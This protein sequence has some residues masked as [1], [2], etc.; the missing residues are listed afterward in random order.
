MPD[1]PGPFTP[2]AVNGALL[3]VPLL[4]LLMALALALFAQ[5][6]SQ[7]S[8]GRIWSVGPTLASTGLLSFLGAYIGLGREPAMVTLAHGVTLARVGWLDIGFDVAFDRLTGAFALVGG[9]LFAALLSWLGRYGASGSRPLASLAL[10]NLASGAFFFALMADAAPAFVFG[11]VASSL[12]LAW[13]A[14]RASARPRASSDFAHRAFGE[15]LLVL[16]LVAL[17]ASFASLDPDA[18]GPLRLVPVSR[19]DAPSQA[20]PGGRPNSGYLTMSALPGASLRTEGSPALSALTAPFFRNVSPAGSYRGRVIPGPGSLDLPFGPTRIA[21][22]AETRLVLA[23]PTVAFRAM[24]EQAT[25]LAPDE[26][27]PE[28]G[29]GLARAGVALVAAGALVRGAFVGAGR[30]RA[31]GGGLAWLSAAPLAMLAAYLLLRLSFAWRPPSA[32]L[33]GLGLVAALATSIGAPGARR[34]A[35]AAEALI[36]LCLA[37][38]VASAGVGAPGAVLAFGVAPALVA[39]VRF[40]HA[41]PRASDPEP[42]TRPLPWAW[43]VPFALIGIVGVSS[44]AGRLP[45]GS[46]GGIALLVALAPPA[47]A[48]ALLYARAL[49]R[50]APAKGTS[51]A[52]IDVMPEALGFAPSSPDFAPSAAFS[53][54][55]FAPD[56]DDLASATGG[57][58][59]AAARVSHASGGFS[60]A[61]G[62]F[63]AISGGFAPAVPRAEGLVLATIV[64]ALSLLGAEAWFGLARANAPALQWTTPGAA[65]GSTRSLAALGVTAAL[66]LIAWFA[67]RWALGKGAAFGEAT[68]AAAGA[69][70]RG[71]RKVW[72]ALGAPGRA[73]WVASS[74]IDRQLWGERSGASAPQ[75]PSE[76]R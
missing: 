22:N 25:L 13:L 70:G 49:G 20:K 29:P 59:P 33:V 4:P 60:R 62:G 30:G 28:H 76:E 68:P 9:S 12:A 16:G 63:G 10:G 21:E 71:V 19:P 56:P 42:G 34:P 54:G 7:A 43:V 1:V 40:A 72:R 53:A 17:G 36:A 52:A 64:A 24:E 61:S 58:A 38:A 32:S 23:G 15:A 31:R 44:F 55:A 57:F 35:D 37:L 75:P 46:A 66:G 3:A 2:L 48:A 39:A 14:A 74:A 41:S 65:W 51:P 67:A 45:L 73:L 11:A 5:G 47:A 69:A 6:R 8:I 26:S 27:A 18:D 50:G